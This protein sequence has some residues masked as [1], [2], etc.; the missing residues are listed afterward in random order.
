MFNEL[1][2]NNPLFNPSRLIYK[3]QPYIKEDNYHGGTTFPTEISWKPS[4][5]IPSNFAITNVRL[6]SFVASMKTCKQ[7]A[8]E[9]RKD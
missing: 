8:C 7:H 6:P 4:P 3:L 2:L 1:N 5:N 9:I